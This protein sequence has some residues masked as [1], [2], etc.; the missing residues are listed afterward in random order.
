MV[1]KVNIPEI[2]QKHLHGIKDLTVDDIN[3][4]L[5]LSKLNGGKLEK[6][7][8]IL[9][10]RPEGHHFFERLSFQNLQKFIPKAS[11]NNEYIVNVRIE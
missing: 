10:N 5:E 6:T 8:L 1:E 2:S 4:I 11:K 7:P 9:E 3:K